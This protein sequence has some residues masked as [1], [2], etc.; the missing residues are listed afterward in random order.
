MT[1][2]EREQV[3][4]EV[5]VYRDRRGQWRWR[6]SAGNGRVVADSGESY[7]NHGHARDMALRIFPGADYVE[8][9]VNP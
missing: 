6:A 2:S 9:E 8:E 1:T 5:R 3:V 7:V 4:A